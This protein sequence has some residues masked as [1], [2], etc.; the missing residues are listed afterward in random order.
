MPAA[1]WPPRPPPGPQC[2]RKRPA[3]R[4]GKNGPRDKRSA[5]RPSGHLRGFGAVWGVRVGALRS[6]AFCSGEGGEPAGPRPAAE[7]IGRERPLDRLCPAPRSAAAAPRPD[8]GGCLPCVATKRPAVCTR[9]LRGV[10][11]CVFASPRPAPALRG[12]LHLAVGGVHASGE[13][14]GRR[15]L[16]AACNFPA[17]EGRNR[18]CAVRKSSLAWRE[19]ERKTRK[20]KED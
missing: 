20:K 4:Q 10:C 6:A 19:A 16:C 13:A 12:A 14:L 9:S 7:G 1:T 15:P 17:P 11:A 18:T 8:A 5:N 3:S 2:A